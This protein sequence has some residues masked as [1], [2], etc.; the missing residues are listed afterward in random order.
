RTVPEVATVFG[1]AGRAES[2]TDPAPLEM[3]ETTI[4][5]K[6]RSEWRS[7]MTPD[8][9]IKEQDKAVQVPG[10]TNIWVPPIRNR[11]D[12]LATGVKSPIGI[13]ISA[14]DLQ[15]IDQVA[16]QV[17]KIARKVPGVSSDLAERLT[18]GRYIDVD[19]N[20]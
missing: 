15:N 12:M 19:I 11:I 20:R 8:K 14:N 16:Q 13:K 17:E 2:A 6:P 18:G 1:K 10:L 7:G 5:F 9:L 3:F 4:Q